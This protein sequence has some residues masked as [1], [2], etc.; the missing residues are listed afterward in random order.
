MKMLKVISTQFQT[1]QRMR[2]RV[3]P[4]LKLNNLKS[5]ELLVTERRLL[6]LS[7]LNTCPDHHLDT[8]GGL[9]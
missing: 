3:F 7:K 2:H 9:V 8:F 5:L 4:T 6:L 1:Q